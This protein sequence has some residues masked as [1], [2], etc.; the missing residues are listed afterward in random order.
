MADHPHIPMLTLERYAL[1]ELAPAERQELEQR[2]ARDPG[3]QRQLDA[4]GRESAQTLATYPPQL[5][6]PAIERRL[7][8][9]RAD[10]ASAQ[11]RRPALRWPLLAPLGGA[12]AAAGLALVLLQPGASL[13]QSADQ[14]EVT[15]IKGLRAQL[16]IF[17]KPAAGAELHTL[18]DGDAVR[19]HDL[20]QVGYV[21][22]G[23]LH[24]VVV[25][26]DGRGETT[27]HFPAT[28]ELTTRLGAGQVLLPSAYELDD[29]PRFERFFL[30]TSARPISTAAVLAAARKLASDEGQ[31]STARLALPPDL[32]QTSLL[33]LKY[34]KNHKEGTAP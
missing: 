1:G 24:G 19:A 33:L 11:L 31:A 30:V 17:A 18:A 23:K 21:A 2:L 8:L 5:T 10:A 32:E 34:N 28:P 9:H 13:R 20:V 29:A 26:I 14:P 25:S 6:V 7:R 15:R 3:M 22:A 27:L 12:L 16:L 4:L